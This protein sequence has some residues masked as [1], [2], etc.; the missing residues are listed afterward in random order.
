VT[1]KEGIK[2]SESLADELKKHVA[3]KIGA[4]ARP[5]DIIFAADLPK[6]RSGKIMRRL[7]RDIA[8]GRRWEIPPRWPTRLSS[9]S[10]KIN[11]SR[12][13]N[14]SSSTRH[15][16]TVM[17]DTQNY[18]NHR[19]F[20]PL[21]HFFVAPVL[22]LNAVNE[23]RH[24]WANPNR[25]TAFAFLVAA[26]LLGGAFAARVMALK[27]QDR[28]IRLELTMRMSNCLPADLKAR[29]SEL[30]PSQMVAL[31]FASDAELPDLMRDVLAGKLAGQNAIKKGIKNW[32]GDFLRA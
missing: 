29:I 7:L 28:V 23:G 30:T 22:L 26:A 12:R 17:A 11:T 3:Q 20:F 5:D 6:T 8:E 32:Q 4:I 2:P 31:R 24:L 19:K 21:F 18:G 16:E 9:R 1:V 15:R 27:V 13:N 14:P 25:S 10:S